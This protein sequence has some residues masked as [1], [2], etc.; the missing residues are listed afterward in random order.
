MIWIV[1]SKLAYLLVLLFG[2]A[3]YLPGFTT[4]PAVDRDEARFAQSSRQMLQTGDYIDIRLQDEARLK[5]PAGIYWLQAAATKLAGGED[6][7][8]PIWTYRLP[9]LI[10]ALGAILMTLAIGRR[11][12]G[13]EAG[14]LGAAVMAATLLLGFEARQ[15][16]TDAFLLLTVTVAMAGLAEAWIAGPPAPI[17]RGWWIAFWAA[18]GAGILIKGPIV[19]MVAG[20][21]AL[22]L[23]LHDRSAVWLKRLRAWPGA[24]ITL[25]IT[26]P[27]LITITIS[28]HGAFWTQSLGGD[29]ASKLAGAQE[30]HG[31]VIGTYL[32]LFPLTFWPGSLFAILALPWVWRNRRDRAVMFCLAWTLPSWIV[33]EIVPTKLPHYVLPLY[34]AIALLTCASLA[35]RLGVAW[36]T[37]W[38]RL[39]PRIVIAVW[40]LTGFVLGGLIVAAGPLGDGRFSIWGTLAAVIVWALTAAG[41]VTCWRGWRGRSVAISL[42]GSVA[43]YGLIFSLALPTLDAPWVA[44]RLEKLLTQKLPGGHGPV[45]IAGYGEPSAVI[46]LGTDIRFGNGADAARFI[47]DNKTAIAIVERDQAQ[48]FD[49]GLIEAH[50]DVETLG[51]VAG[52]NYAKG[53][54]VTLTIW[55]VAQ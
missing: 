37:G 47:A 54:R 44:P 3:L 16:K 9:S 43:A 10:G 55:R 5:K 28:S 34:P 52:F 19:V 36:A 12:L 22:A 41:A 45:L 13:L 25:G 35:D 51:S 8:N 18:I 26:L 20:L 17:R 24:A 14:F 39:L 42:A 33:F 27:W 6:A 40:G 53:K 29:M 7:A 46:A 11:W 21:T 30:S 15:A 1:R 32:A 31:G 2:L 48:A 50:I 49:A 23:T 4:I 38:R